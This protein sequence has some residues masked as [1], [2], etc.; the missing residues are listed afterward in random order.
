MEFGKLTTEEL[1]KADLRLPPEPLS[2][3][4]ILPGKPA[5]KK[6][7][8]VGCSKWGRTEWVGTLYPQRTKEKDF[9]QNYVQHYNCVELNATHYKA[10]GAGAISKWKEKAGNKDFKFC[11][12]MYK[13]VT[14]F[15]NLTGKEFIT[16]EFLRGVSAFE[17]KLGP[18]FLQFD[19]RFSVNRKDELFKYL[20]WLPK[21]FEF[22]LELRHHKWFQPGE[23]ETLTGFLKNEKIGLVIT[24]TAGRRDCVH[25][26]LTLPKTF[27]RFLGN[28]LH[29]T[30][31]SRTDEWSKRIHSWLDKGIEE[32][33]FMVHSG[34]ETVSPEVTKYVAETFNKECGLSI[35]E[36]KF[37]K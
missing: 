7:V 5:L 36:I 31:L 33:Y 8:Y 18:I 15:R 22:F 35:P 21:N 17:D 4:G 25:M 16:N 34:D 10:Y 9:L 11:P 32:V 19:D 23:L 28:S 6:K 27:I 2:N 14:H 30:D 1:E 29:P 37:I 13:N 24:D 3:S 12:K 26:R 20:S